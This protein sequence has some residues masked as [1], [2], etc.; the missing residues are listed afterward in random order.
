MMKFEAQTQ[1]CIVNYQSQTRALDSSIM[2]LPGY[3]SL[4]SSF[5]PFLLLLPASYTEEA[6]ARGILMKVHLDAI[7]SELL[8]DCRVH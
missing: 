2:K 5:P 1:G 3:P 6:E 7:D 8:K 4:L